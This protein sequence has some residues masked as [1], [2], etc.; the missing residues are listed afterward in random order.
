MSG[1]SSPALIKSQP[2]PKIQASKKE[3]SNSV[4]KQRPLV[5]QGRGI[6]QWVE[7]YGMVG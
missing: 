4:S 7:Y 5:G 6:A 3:T 2:L 1:K